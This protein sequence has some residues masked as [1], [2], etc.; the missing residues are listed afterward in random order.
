MS[1]R[2]NGLAAVVRAAAVNDD[3]LDTGGVAWL[4]HINIVV[5]S[6]SVAESFYVDFLGCTADPS[7]SFHVNLGRQQFHLNEGSDEEA[8]VLSGS[9]GIAVPSLDSLRSRVEPATAALQGTQF[10]CVDHGTALEA[11]CPW[12]NKFFVYPAAVP[13]EAKA[14]T[15]EDAPLLARRHAGWDHGMGVNGDQPGLRYI[16]IRLP[17][18]AAQGVGRFYEKSLGCYVMFDAGGKGAV[19]ALGPGVHAIFTDVPGTTPETL[20]RMRGLHL[21]IYI[22]GFKRAFE[23]L[24]ACGLTWTNPRFAHLDRCDTWEE[25]KA[26][27]QFRF[28]AI[29]DPSVETP[30][31]AEPLLELEHETRACRHQQF[32]KTVEYVGR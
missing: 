3:S 22:H 8:H 15:S 19:V 10:A 1:R 2:A 18:G 5:G 16:E 25:A 27:R 26:S 30:S 6:R 13:A 21:C 31:G 11:T 20:A 23:Q 17:P 14:A 28:R 12:G 29:H 4:E 32:M 7:A 24:Q 9:L